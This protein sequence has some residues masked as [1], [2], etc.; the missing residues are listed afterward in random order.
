MCEFF[1]LIAAPG[2]DAGD[3]LHHAKAH[4]PGMTSRMKDGLGVTVIRADGT[5]ET[6]KMVNPKDHMI[7][8]DT[9]EPEDDP[10][11]C[12]FPFAQQKPKKTVAPTL[13]KT[14]IW[15]IIWHARMATNS[16]GGTAGV[17]PFIGENYV[18]SHNGVVT[19]PNKW[20]PN[21]DYHDSRALLRALDAEGPEAWQDFT[22][23]GAIFAVHKE[24]GDLNIW[25]DSQARLYT[26]AL[27]DGSA[28]I[29][30]KPPSVE[31]HKRDTAPVWSEFLTH[32]HVYMK[33]GADPQEAEVNE[34][35]GF[36]PKFQVQP[37]PSRYPASYPSQQQF[38]QDWGR[39]WNEDE[40]RKDWERKAKEGRGKKKSQKREP[41][42]GGN[43]GTTITD[44]SSGTGKE[45]GQAIVRALIQAEIKE[46]IRSVAAKAA[47]VNARITRRIEERKKEAAN[48]TPTVC[49]V[50]TELDK[51]DMEER[52]F[53]A[54]YAAWMGKMDDDG[55]GH[56]NS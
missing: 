44:G 54:E 3:L 42:S 41:N 51:R 32:V 46:D 6:A 49:E 26:R 55:F 52:S 11:N 36:A 14:N 19:P 2:T 39:N 38:N 22:G 33:C 23:Y 35:I 47:E 12:P 34:W 10:D 21:G 15:A 20:T 17:H 45:T 28:L 29:A 13:D 31:Y 56:Y 1:A 37:A 27:Q 16:H 25:R 8:G 24:T 5:I 30:T 48:S 4:V 43:A 50:V 18:L 9:P 7:V 40:W 53:T